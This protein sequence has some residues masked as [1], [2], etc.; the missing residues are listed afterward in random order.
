M[1]TKKCINPVDLRSLAM[2]SRLNA[3]P[4]RRPAFVSALRA[5]ASSSS[6]TTPNPLNS[7]LQASDP[8]LFE[9]MEREK[10]RQVLD[11]VAA[12]ATGI[13][14]APASTRIATPL[15]KL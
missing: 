10:H 3:S 1:K 8:E 12:Y 2:L 9:I 15:Q 7:S 6:A 11:A 5:F 4:I 14:T 13:H